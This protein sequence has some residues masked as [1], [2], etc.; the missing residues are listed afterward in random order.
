MY[1]IILE[2]RTTTMAMQQ[3]FSSTITTTTTPQPRLITWTIPTTERTSIGILY[4]SSWH[5]LQSQDAL[6][7]CFANV[8]IHGASSL[9]LLVYP[10]F[11]RIDSGAH[12]I[13][14][15]CLHRIMGLYWVDSGAQNHCTCVFESRVVG[16]IVFT[17]NCAVIH[18]R[19]VLIFL[20]FSD[21]TTD[22][23][24]TKQAYKSI[25]YIR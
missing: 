7:I 23:N 9:R 16:A 10:Y 18:T 20:L 3:L 14:D 21:D 12:S 15:D 25:R 22:I 6:Y 1:Q 4:L 2:T 19:T 13:V 8:V 17:I 24:I 11:F 5:F